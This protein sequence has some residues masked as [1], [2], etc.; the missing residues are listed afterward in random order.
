MALTS[1]TVVVSSTGTITGSGFARDLFDA[2]H[3]AIDGVEGGPIPGGS[4][5]SLC[6]NAPGKVCTAEVYRFRIT[7]AAICN[8]LS[9]T[10]IAAGL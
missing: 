4:N 6:P 5:D 1:G 9:A 10:M 8:S 2:L 3:I 7:L